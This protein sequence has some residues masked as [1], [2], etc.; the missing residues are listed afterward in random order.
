MA[1]GGASSTLLSS[2]LLATPLAYAQINVSGCTAHM[3]PFDV[4]SDLFK[5]NVHVN[6]GA[7]LK[8][9]YYHRLF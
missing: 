2:A 3:L 6:E 9:I 8:L 4:V 7:A 5:A 1:S